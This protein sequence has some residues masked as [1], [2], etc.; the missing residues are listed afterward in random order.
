MRT[1]FTAV[2]TNGNVYG[3][4]QDRVVSSKVDA[5]CAHAAQHLALWHASKRARRLWRQL[6]RR[7][8]AVMASAA[9]QSRLMCLDTTG[10]QGLLARHTSPALVTA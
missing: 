4:G 6:K 8:P 5:S 10:P 9:P 1:N 7:I 2:V 3:F